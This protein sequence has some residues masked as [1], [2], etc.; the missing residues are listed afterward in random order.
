MRA[1]QLAA[2]SRIKHESTEG[3]EILVETVDVD[4]DNVHI[5]GVWADDPNS[6]TGL[7]VPIGTE[8]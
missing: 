8:L 4:G 7:I 2:G 5:N 6:N 1:E 3:R